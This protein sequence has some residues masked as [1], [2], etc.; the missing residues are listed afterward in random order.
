LIIFH[1]LFVNFRTSDQKQLQAVKAK[2]VVKIQLLLSLTGLVC[3]LLYYF[4]VTLL[5]MILSM[6]CL[7]NIIMYHL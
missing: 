4:S 2:A 7:C 3:K 5:M 1:F 6:F